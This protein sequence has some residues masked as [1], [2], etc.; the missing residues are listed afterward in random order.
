[1]IKI[2]KCTTNSDFSTA[3]QITKD[4]IAWLNIDLSFQNIEKELSNFTAMYNAPNGLFL[5]AWYNGKIS[6]GIGLRF[7]DT[8]VCEMKRLYVYDKFKKKG[9]GRILCTELIKE[10]T[11]LGYV[12]MRLDTLSRLGEAINL[13]ENLGFKIIKPYRFNPDPTTKYM[14]LNLR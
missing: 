14:E 4:Y 10:A 13:Y 12:K 6:G 11:S 9:I 1:M 2:T 8:I 5:L 7:L 3:I